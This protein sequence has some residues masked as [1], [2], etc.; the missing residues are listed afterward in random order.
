MSQK[1]TAN[2]KK[3]MLDQRLARGRTT[4]KGGSVADNP[5][6]ADDHKQGKGRKKHL[7][8]GRLKKTKKH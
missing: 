3:K 5:K 8:G 4:T 1:K 6:E 2:P 7:K